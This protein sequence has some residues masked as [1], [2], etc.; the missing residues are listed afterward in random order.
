MKICSGKKKFPLETVLSSP[1]LSSCT[2][3]VQIKEEARWKIQGKLQRF[4]CG[5][6]LLYL[7]IFRTPETSLFISAERVSQAC[8]IWLSGQVVLYL[9]RLLCII[10][11]HY[12]SSP[13]K[14]FF[15]LLTFTVK[16][17]DGFIVDRLQCN[18]AKCLSDLHQG[19]P[20]LQHFFH[21]VNISALLFQALKYS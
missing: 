5:T 10:H 12:H 9:K 1:I 17:S 18:F 4:A 8:A 3:G 13:R 15:F 6:S 2:T 14:C 19:F 11:G 7:N 16:H 20:H 21:K